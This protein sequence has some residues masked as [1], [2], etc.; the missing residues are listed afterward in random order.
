[1]KT[2]FLWLSVFALPVLLVS[3]ALGGPLGED[4]TSISGYTGTVS[5]NASDVLFVDLDYAVFMPGI[6]PDDGVNGD[7][8]SDG[9]EYV[10]A[11]QA[12]NVSPGA[13][14]ST[15][16]IGLLEDNGAGNAMADLLHE[17]LG[18]VEPSL[19]DC[20]SA[21]IV[22]RFSSPVI[23]PDQYSTVVLFTSPN[24]PTWGPASVQ[25]GGYTDQQTVP[26]PIPEPAAGLLLGLV[27][28]AAIARR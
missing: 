14:L 21:S 28:L 20:Y 1:M 19:I 13:P 24:S 15:V 27:G 11:Y 4:S 17:Q 26:T 12:F 18:G 8:P 10:Y 5:F 23:M 9:T 22:Y 16:S 25:Y 3:T 2:L 7:D 6:Y